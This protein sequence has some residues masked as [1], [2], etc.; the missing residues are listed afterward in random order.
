M[1]VGEG[2]EAREGL[3]V[4]LRLVHLSGV[5]TAWALGCLVSQA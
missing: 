5:G 4:A 2:A 1:G 3:V